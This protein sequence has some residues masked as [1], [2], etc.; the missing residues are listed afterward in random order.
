MRQKETAQAEDQRLKAV[1]EAFWNNTP[2]GSHDLK[3]LRI[4]LVASDIVEDPSAEQIKAF[5]MLLPADIFGSALSWG[6]GDTEVRERT[7]EFVERNKQAV[8]QAIKAVP[9]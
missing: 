5:F 9:A 4:I 2:D 3:Q 7:F 6:F 1:R 8:L